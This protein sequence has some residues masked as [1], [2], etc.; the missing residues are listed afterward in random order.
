MPM[1]DEDAVVVVR[2]RRLMLLLMVVLAVPVTRRIGEALLEG[3]QR[4][5][6]VLDLQ[7]ELRAKQSEHD[8]LVAGRNALE[9]PLGRELAVRRGLEHVREGQRILYFDG[10]QTPREALADA[11]RR[12]SLSDDPFEVLKYWW[13][14]P[15]KSTAE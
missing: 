2:R 9:T 8:R 1:Q 15:H 4:A 10:H 6:R 3:Y 11:V 5:A 13:H 14:A 7:E 12:P